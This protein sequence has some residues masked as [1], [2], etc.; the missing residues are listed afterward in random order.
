L[1][2][3]SSQEEARIPRQKPD[4]AVSGPGN[5]RLERKPQASGHRTFLIATSDGAGL[6]GVP[7][8]AV[9]FPDGHHER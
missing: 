5:F 6:A 3:Q 7:V 2:T 8:P 1:A 9:R 4:Q